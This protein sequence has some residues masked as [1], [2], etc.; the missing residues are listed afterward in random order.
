VSSDMNANR[1]WWYFFWGVVL[2]VALR[3]AM[4]GA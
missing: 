2:V 1:R 3:T 4:L